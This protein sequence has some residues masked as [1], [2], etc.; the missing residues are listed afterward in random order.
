MTL[1]NTPNILSDF[2]RQERLSNKTNGLVQFN[3]SRQRGHDERAGFVVDVDGNC[4]HTAST[5]QE[6]CVGSQFA[7]CSWTKIVQCEVYCDGLFFGFERGKDGEGRG[8]VGQGSERPAVHNAAESLQIGMRVHGQRGC[9]AR[10]V[11][12]VDAEQLRVRHAVDCLAQAAQL[13]VCQWS[14]VQEL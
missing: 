5:T 12:K 13:C 3:V 8:R 6:A 2:A 10:R 4:G 1:F 9:S 7:F 11:F 14:V